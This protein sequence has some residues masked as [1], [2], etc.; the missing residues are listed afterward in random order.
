MDQEHD[1]TETSVP[2]QSGAVS[3]VAARAGDA[4]RERAVAVLR[5]A[6]IQGR[7]TL[8]E[9]SERVERA[10]QAR[11]HD[12][13]QALS[14][15]LPAVPAPAPAV[16]KR[17]GRWVVATRLDRVGPWR[18]PDG[19]ELKV[20]C[21]TVVLDLGQAIVD[22]PVTTLAIRNLCSTVTILV[23]DGIRVEID[24]GGMFLTHEVRLSEHSAPASAPLIRI[25]TSGVAGTNY[26]RSAAA[27]GST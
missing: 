23:P 2:E 11:T 13:L 8:E 17:S 3:V 16:P 25:R 27:H 6:T 22:S 14:A 7:L 4:D 21:G 15:D 5:D 10:L 12:E 20:A 24:D 19:Y 9:F 18:L 26:I 1:V